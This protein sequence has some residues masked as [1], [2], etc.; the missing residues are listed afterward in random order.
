[1]RRCCSFSAG[2]F[3]STDPDLRARKDPAYTES[4]QALQTFILKHSPQ[5]LAETDRGFFLQEKF[6]HFVWYS[7]GAA[8]LDRKNASNILRAAYERFDRKWVTSGL[9][10]ESLGKSQNE[11]TGGR[12]NAAGKI[13]HAVS[14]KVIVLLC[15]IL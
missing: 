6:A 1:M 14:T 4:L 12:N 10:G 9:A 7:I 13:S 2:H 3:Q 5:L 15:N 8:Q 11:K